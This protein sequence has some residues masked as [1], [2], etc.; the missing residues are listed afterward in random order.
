MLRFQMMRTGVFQK[1]DYGKETN[2]IKYGSE[3]APLYNVSKL[4]E[5]DVEKHLYIGTKDYLA[6][7]VDYPFLLENLPK[8]STFSNLV[9]DYS[10]LDYVWGTDAYELIY[11]DII[12]VLESV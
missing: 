9:N 5:F 8:D 7:L 11:K 1:Y 3:E 6:N 4:L 10:H 12:R 2:K